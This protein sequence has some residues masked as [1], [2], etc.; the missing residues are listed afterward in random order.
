MMRCFHERHL[1]GL[2]H[3]VFAFFV[4]GQ[5][6][7][8]TEQEPLLFFER[9]HW[10]HKQTLKH[11]VLN[12]FMHKIRDKARQH[13]KLQSSVITHPKIISAPPTRKQPS[14]KPPK[15]PSKKPPKEPSKKLSKEQ[16]KT[17]Y[18]NIH[19]RDH[20][21][22]RWV[23]QP[24]IEKPS[25]QCCG[26][27]N[28]FSEQYD[29][30][31]CDG[32]S[33]S[34]QKCAAIVGEYGVDFKE[35]ITEMKYA[36][37]GGNACVCQVYGNHNSNENGTATLRDL[38][39]YIWQPQEC[40]LLDWNGDHF[41]SLL[42]DRKIL[43]VG[44]STV[45][46]AGVTLLNMLI[47]GKAKCVHNVKLTR[48]D[49]LFRP[50]MHLACSSYDQKFV[51]TMN[52][53]RPNISI[54]SAGSHLSGSEDMENVFVELRDFLYEQMHLQNVSMIWRSQHPG[55]ATCDNYSIPL[56]SDAH[57]N[58][59][60]EDDETYRWKAFRIMD[61]I[62]REKVY[63]SDGD[64]EEYQFFHGM[65]YLD[66]SMLFLRPDAHPGAFSKYFHDNDDFVDCLHF[67]M[68]GPYDLFPILLL[69]MLFNKEI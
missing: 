68:P 37:A 8:M 22:G 31:Y 40:S 41:C 63:A 26:D 45:M 54:F 44:D 49:A 65:K 16:S 55:H 21:R 60:Q 42:G 30:M 53:V 62:V 51:D 11:K 43:I 36:Q 66:M 59:S 6:H 4:A 39:K 33:R 48:S 17:L 67:C 20:V 5:Q 47:E 28:Y 35:N 1:L 52:S 34:L 9:H 7:Q 2:L 50:T 29:E 12:E 19:N 10:K 25:F 58:S 15:E 32:K 56:T 38:Q 24:S 69:Q 23:Y 46:Q 18:C 3:I 27:I 64:T 57:L 14:K 61:D 13:G